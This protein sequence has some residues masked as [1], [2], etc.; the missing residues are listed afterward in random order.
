MVHSNGSAPLL[1]ALSSAQRLGLCCLGP[2]MIALSFPRLG[3]SF[4]VPFALIPLLRGTTGLT[5]SG[6]AL[7]G[8]AGGIVG[9]TVACGWILGAVRTFQEVSAWRAIPAF[10]VSQFYHGG[11]FALFAG[12]A[13]WLRNGRVRVPL[14]AT[15]SCWVLLE[16]GYPKLARWSLGDVTI[17]WP[18]IPQIADLVGTLGIGFLV[19][20][21]SIVLFNAVF[22]GNGS[23]RP[24]WAP[25]LALGACYGCAALYGVLRIEH[26]DAL[27]TAT[28][29]EV[30]IV[31]TALPVGESDPQ[32]ASARAWESYAARSTQP[33]LRGVDLLVWPETIIRE[34]LRHGSHYTAEIEELAASLDTVLVL[35]ALDLP[36]SGRGEF[37]AAYAFGADRPIQRAHK[38]RLLPFGEYIPGSEW[39]PWLSSWRTT[40][41]FLPG[42]EHP[43][44]NAAGM[45]IASSICFEA[46]F[47]GFNNN[48]LL[49]GA[50]LLVN[51]SNDGWFGDSNLPYMHLQAARWRALEARRWMVRA[52]NSGISAII[53]PTGRVVASIP[54]GQAGSLRAPVFAE[55][56]LTPFVRWGNWFL[57]VQLAL[58]G[59]GC[60]IRLRSRDV[61]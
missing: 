2:V 59:L 22:D 7:F 33:D 61:A 5:V 56:E 18:Y 6:A 42:T 21:T 51:L 34:Y 20:A 54:Y 23:R 16:W 25:V 53:S 1:R 43:I 30:G 48:Q 31:Q 58:F 38:M 3:W 44:L 45:Q 35:G 47:P 17:D 26:F 39:F 8:W 24:R 14:A 28:R 52:S 36:R 9:Y 10:V 27:E 4:L 41:S 55:T 32:R 15:A 19:A 37:S 57:R 29:A 60:F 50:D 40:G 46:V 12:A 13:T 11:Q 49:E